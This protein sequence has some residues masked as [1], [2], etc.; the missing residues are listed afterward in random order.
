MKQIRKLSSILFDAAGFGYVLISGVALLFFGPV[1]VGL[2]IWAVRLIKRARED[3][4]IRLVNAERE[5][6]TD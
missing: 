3:K 5:K 1:V 6:Q 4:R 2:V